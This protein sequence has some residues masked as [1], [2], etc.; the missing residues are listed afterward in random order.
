MFFYVCFSLCSVHTIQ[1]YDES[2]AAQPRQH[3]SDLP[4]LSCGAQRH[5]HRQGALQ[6]LE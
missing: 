3:V 2:M 6:S 5:P 1:F 4:V